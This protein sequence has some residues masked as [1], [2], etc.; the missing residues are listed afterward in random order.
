MTISGADSVRV[1]WTGTG[2]GTMTLGAAVDKFQAFPAA[3]DGLT[4]GY[5]IEHQGDGVV[6]VE[7]GRG[8]YTHSGTT[9]TRISGSVTFSTNSNALVNFSAGTKHVSLVLLWRDIAEIVASIVSTSGTPTEVEATPDTGVYALSTAVRSNPENVT[10]VTA[11]ADTEFQVPEDFVP[12]GELYHFRLLVQHDG[13]FLDIENAPSG[14]II[15]GVE[16]GDPVPLGT[17][18]STVD[19][20][21]R[22]AN[23]VRVEGETG[24][25]SIALARV[26]MDGHPTANMIVESET[27]NTA[28][29]ASGTLAVDLADGT[30]ISVALSEDVSTHTISNVPTTGR[31]VS[32]TYRIIQD[33]SDRTMAWP[34]AFDWGAAGA[35][36]LSSGSGTVTIV[37]AFTDDGGTKWHAMLAWSE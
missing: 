10:L 31:R 3:L 17:A 22:T 6:E 1:A 4:V 20:F 29:S 16:D 9:L 26:D 28:T 7:N 13:C 14:M 5:R 37:T 33:S 25:D 27:L 34:A 24:E 12:A 8:I 35:P 30:E 15:N 18:G 23:V 32:I 36:T 19:I 21:C 11:A 2:T